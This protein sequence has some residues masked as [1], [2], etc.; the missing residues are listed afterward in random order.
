MLGPHQ[1]ELVR[2]F[3]RAPVRTRADLV[4]ETGLSRAVLSSRVD[5][6]TRGGWVEVLDRIPSASRGRP[7]ERLRLRTDAALF[8]VIE[9]GRTTRISVFTVDGRLVAER[10]LPAGL[11]E[12]LAEVA[13]G[14]GRAREE[15]GEEGI[16][17]PLRTIVVVTSAIDG[18]S[19]PRGCWIHASWQDADLTSVLAAAGVPADVENDADVNAY[20]VAEGT[21]ALLAVIVGEGIGTGLVVEGRLRRG[22]GGTAGEIGHLPVPSVRARSCACGKHGCL[23]TVASISAMVSDAGL[24]PDVH[25]VTALE[26]GIRSGDPRTARTVRVA[27][28]ALGT[29]LLGAVVVTAVDRV[30]VRSGSRALDRLLAR[31]I[32]SALAEVADPTVRSPVTVEPGSEGPGDARRGA[33]RL[34]LDT[35]L[36]LRSATD[37]AT[38][39]RG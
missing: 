15:L 3:L 1:A 38:A 6:L 20:A 10:T 14:I 2:A 11:D 36:Q 31:Q 8:E 7:T 12:P 37:Q 39:G 21:E 32:E 33:V 23:I 30:V 9:C 29:V 28:K 16:A 17:A 19:R 22:R 18:R 34:G 25:G 24:D 13:N 35:L 4:Q 27:G 5:E 26:S